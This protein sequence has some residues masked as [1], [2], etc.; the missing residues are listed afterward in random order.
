MKLV[1]IRK[2]MSLLMMDIDKFKIIND[3]YGHP[4]GDIVSKKGNEYL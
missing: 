4:T 2:H 1:R 3:T